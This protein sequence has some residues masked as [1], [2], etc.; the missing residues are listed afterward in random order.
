MNVCIVSTFEGTT[1]DYMEMFNATK[2]NSQGI[3]QE[4]ELGV[5]REGKVM[6]MMQISDMSKMQEVMNSDEMQAWDE[7][8]NSVDEIYILDKIN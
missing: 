3:M 2:E 4:Y 7:K 1:E 5:V 6:L 8:F